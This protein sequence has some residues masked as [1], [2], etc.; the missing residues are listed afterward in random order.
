MDNLPMVKQLADVRYRLIFEKRYR[1]SWVSISFCNDEFMP[2]VVSYRGSGHYFKSAEAAVA[3][4]AGRGF[5]KYTEI[6]AV[7]SSIRA[8]LKVFQGE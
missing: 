1:N 2:W 4:A 8:K 6:E 7:L 5:I 3:Y